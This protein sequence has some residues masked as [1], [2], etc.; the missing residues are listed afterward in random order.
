MSNIRI[1]VDDA[2]ARF[3]ALGNPHRL[4]L[5]L[6]LVSC[7]PPG[8]ACSGTREEVATCVGDLV[9]SLHLAP[10]TIS[11]H[12]RE[13]R[14]AGLVRMERRGQRVECSVVAEALRG[15]EEFFGAAHGGALTEEI[16]P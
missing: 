9:A 7:C 1:D 5:L 3:R 13:L 8:T 16:E 14:R 6:R 2:A 15:L 12:L 10:S 11:H 4:R